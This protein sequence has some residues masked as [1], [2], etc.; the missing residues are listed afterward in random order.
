MNLH[1]LATLVLTP[2]PK[3]FAEAITTIVPG[4][5]VVVILAVLV[6]VVIPPHTPDRDSPDIPDSRE[7]INNF[8]P[9]PPRS[10]GRSDASWP[11]RKEE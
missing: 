9:P 7:S 6:L 3:S 11:T 1:V 4:A 2:Q 5:L 10:H 8:H